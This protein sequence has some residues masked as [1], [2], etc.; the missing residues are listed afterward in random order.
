M[1]I[2]FE[3]DFLCH[4][5][6][7]TPDGW[8]V[9]QHADLS[10]TLRVV[11]GGVCEITFPG[12]KHFP[13]IPEVKNFA[14][15]CRVRGDCHSE[16]MALRIYFRYH[17][18]HCEGYCILHRWGTKGTET[19]L[20]VC[21]DNDFTTIVRRAGMDG[22]ARLSPDRAHTIR[23]EVRDDEFV[24]IHNGKAAA[25]LEDPERRF[26]GPGLVGL[27][28]SASNAFFYFGLQGVR[29]E[30]GE[31]LPETVLW[32]L[33]KIEFPSDINGMTTPFFLGIKAVRSGPRV[34]LRT[35]L[36]G[37]PAAR[38]PS[39]LDFRGIWANAKLLNPYIRLE[40]RGGRSIGP[41]FLF[42]GSVGLR[43][44]W[45][46]QSSGFLPADV[47]CPVGHAVILPDIPEDAFL[48]FGYE[49]YAAED[50]LPLAGGPSEIILDPKTGKTIY[51]GEA[52]CPSGVKLGIESPPDK[53]ICSLLPGTDPRRFQ[54]LEFAKNNHFFFE[55]EP[56]RFR[57]VIR[58]RDQ[59]LN[60]TRLAVQV[61]LQDAYRKTIEKLNDF[62]L[63][64]VDD[65][66]A[67]TLLTAAGIV[68]L[69]TDWIGMSPLKTGV[70][71]LQ[72][73]LYHG[74]G[75]VVGHRKAFEV[76]SEDPA[77]PCPP[78]ASGLPDLI[79]CLPDYETEAAGF[80]P[81]VGRG[82]DAAHYLS[83]TCFHPLPARKY[84][85]W[86]VVHLYRRQWVLELAG[87][88][89]P[90]PL[91]KHNLDLLRHCD[92]LYE[93]G[94]FDLWLEHA[95]R[96]MKVLSVLT[97]FLNST[98][99]KPGAGSL[100]NAGAIEKDKSISRDMYCELVTRHWKSWIAFFN[101][102]NADEELPQRRAELA[103]INPKA[104]LMRYSIYPPYGSTYK[105]AYFASYMGRDLA[106]RL[107]RFWDGPLLFEDYPYMCGY[108]LQRG[109]FML[110]AM[111]L[112]APALRQYP[113][114]Y[115]INGCADDSRPVFGIPP[116]GCS[117]PPPGYFRKTVFEYTCAAVWFDAEGFH[118]WDDR[119]FQAMCWTNE[120]FE[121]FLDTWGIIAR[122]R[123][124]MP[125]RVT[126]FGYSRE[127]CRKH[128][129]QLLECRP[130]PDMDAGFP[131]DDIVN[132]AEE[133]VAFAYELARLDGQAAGFIL[134][135]DHLDRLSP[136]VL[137][138]IVLPPLAG[139]SPET[140]KHIRRLHEK[141][142]ALIGFEDVSGLEDLFGI[143]CSEQP[144]TIKEMGVT[145]AGHK[146]GFQT[147]LVP[148]E[149]CETPACI[150]R[151][152][153][154]GC[155]VILDGRDE[156]GRNVAPVLVRHRTTWGQTAFFTVPPTMVRRQSLKNLVSY[157]K[158]SIS[159][160]VNGAMT[161]I[162]RQLARPQV[163]TTA[164]KLIAFRDAAGRAHVVVEEDA[165]PA[166]ARPIAPMV[167]LRM[168]GLKP[169]LIRCDRPF[170]LLEATA[171]AV[172]IQIQLQ[173]HDSAHVQMEDSL[174][175]NRELT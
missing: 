55:S 112:E 160:L 56:V 91:M 168:P 37:G 34:I 6:G 86:D 96:D 36:T 27:D 67:N 12:N 164:G 165:H 53:K 72:A 98:E 25:R 163:E 131:F 82:V 90:Q 119:G 94:R 49:H 60:T 138:T 22:D 155:D 106:N 162:L 78:L 110:A 157:G 152:R 151:H 62:S 124:K 100:L 9:E 50:R 159:P 174:S 63:K 66:T 42:R 173:P 95:Y 38:L 10:H 170:N 99:Y 89:T 142:V 51:A 64:P 28:R 59:N 21:R 103:E 8:R 153:E 169:E 105:T 85:I 116:Y 33:R 102:W 104:K 134:A 145:T 80:D 101:R 126:A 47:E 97:R 81:W 31:P 113:E 125:L 70:Y 115:G 52:L 88:M 61:T 154:N 35:R 19:V 166:A 122:H 26:T 40:C 136:D 140:Q 29:I 146:Q 76:M 32:K 111:K 108:P 17:P 15:T 133:S 39:E 7:D 150:V 161:W 123:P 114:V 156:N 43:E 73:A 92:M 18:D 14:M 57:M 144:V 84:R 117:C 75:Q 167:T 147:P 171:D 172:R 129:D 5:E 121:E 16:S 127:S 30:S 44:H 130:N 45:N 148:R 87:R 83:N 24:L 41:Y 135:L 1:R 149:T 175:A 20:G 139:L 69:A 128:A 132:T 71:H 11:R 120:H 3:D 141:G 93:H 109:V 13:L 65:P 77:A 46:P 118:Y 143:A 2:V 158:E 68:T 79:P 48:A 137:D 54:A 74:D 4:A 107:E 23:L 58:H